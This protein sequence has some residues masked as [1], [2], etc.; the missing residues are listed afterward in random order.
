MTAIT[1][2]VLTGTAIAEALDDVATLRLEIFEEF[3]YLYRGHRG[4]ELK[5][6]GT[7]ASTPDAC[8]ILAF[9][10]ITSYNVC[11]TKLLRFNG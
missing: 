4:D 5:Y 10:R 3:P 6:L 9:D 7:Y 1:E 2:T 8:V 11:Y